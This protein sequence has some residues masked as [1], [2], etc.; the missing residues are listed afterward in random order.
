ME[1]I[2]F[3][4]GSNGN[5]GKSL[6]KYELQSNDKK[7]IGIDKVDSDI[8]HSRY[9]Q[10]NCDCILPEKIESKLRALFNKKKFMVQNL[11]LCAVMDFTIFYEKR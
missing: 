3:I 5:I 7:I 10:W 1:K 6:V 11:V 4:I 9:F 2:T 8:R